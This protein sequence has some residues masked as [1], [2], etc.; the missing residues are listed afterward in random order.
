MTFH[1]GAKQ[2]Q[3]RTRNLSR[4]GVCAL[5]ADT[6]PNGASVEL[7]L[8]LIFDEDT[9]SEKLRLPGRIAW[10][11]PLDEGY[12]IGLSFRSLDAEQHEYLTIFL[13]YL[14]DGAQRDRPFVK[15]A[16]LDDRFR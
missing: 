16:N 14:D 10:C 8:Q 6:L 7:D 5:V 15:S 12:Q 1:H 13:K 2:V 3:G 11:T 4:G 9:Q